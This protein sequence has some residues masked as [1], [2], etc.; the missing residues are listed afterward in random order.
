[1]KKK[2]REEIATGLNC[3]ERNLMPFT[4][5]SSLGILS[6]DL[7]RHLIPATFNFF[8]KK[9]FSSFFPKTF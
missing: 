7:S 1:M 2:S 6:P 5:F 3:R 4:N 8:E 9:V